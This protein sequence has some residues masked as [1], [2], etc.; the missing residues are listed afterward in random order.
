MTLT[1]LLNHAHS[2]PSQRNQI[3]RKCIEM[4]KFVG[5]KVVFGRLVN[6]VQYDDGTYG[7]FIQH[8]KNLRGSGR[9][10]DQTF[11]VDDAVVSNGSHVRGKSQIV[12]DSMVLY[13]EVTDSFISGNAYVDSS[14]LLNSAVSDATVRT[15]SV[16]VDSAVRD[17]ALVIESQLT[18]SLVNGMRTAISS[19]ILHGAVVDSARLDLHLAK[20]TNGKGLVYV[21][22]ALSSGRI[23][24]FYKSACNDE[25]RATAGCFQ[26]T[27]S[28][29]RERV[30]L[31]HGRN[32]A[33]FSWYMDA[34]EYAE[35]VLSK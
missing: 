18:K 27:I 33:N 16:L 31:V 1:H 12:G 3:C 28:E 26:G 20:L 23:V 29:L 10:Y 35:K 2:K 6:W 17:G 25:L 34:I 13:S 7:G 5:Q 30:M 24:A 22:P 9:V 21:G 11:V 19:S 32:Q 15:N 14:N 8:R 4:Y